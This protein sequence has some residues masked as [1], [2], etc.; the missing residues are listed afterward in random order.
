[1]WVQVPMESWAIHAASR[2]VTSAAAF[3]LSASASSLFSATTSIVSSSAL[4]LACT[5]V[6]TDTY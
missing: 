3:C 5:C 2:V 4:S 1:M 6:G